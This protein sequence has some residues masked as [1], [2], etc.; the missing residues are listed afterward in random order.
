MKLSRNKHCSII[1]TTIETLNK[2][3]SKN[4]VKNIPRHSSLSALWT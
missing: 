2:S 3:L 1:H 4:S